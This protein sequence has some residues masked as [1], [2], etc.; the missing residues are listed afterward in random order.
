MAL[1]AII[2]AVGTAALTVALIGS[3]DARPW[4]LLVILCFGGL[5]ALDSR[6]LRSRLPNP[7]FDVALDRLYRS[8][9]QLQDDV[10][11]SADPAITAKDAVLRRIT[12]WD[13]QLGK[14]LSP[15]GARGDIER[16]KLRGWVTGGAWE[17]GLREA[18]SERLDLLERLLR[19]YRH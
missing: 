4:F 12:A 7:P 9:K 1:R 2:L 18:V 14:G 13:K 3:G 16:Q 8:G 10:I 15:L 17:N 6:R 11:N 5:L 19:E